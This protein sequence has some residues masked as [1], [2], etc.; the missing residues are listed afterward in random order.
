MMYKIKDYNSQINRILNNTLEESL[1][2]SIKSLKSVLQNLYKKNLEHKINPKNLDLNKDDILNKFSDIIIKYFFALENCNYKPIYEIIFYMIELGADIKN[3][4]NNPISNLIFKITHYSNSNNFNWFIYKILKHVIRKG[5]CINCIYI[6]YRRESL[7]SEVIHKYLIFEDDHNLKYT[8]KIVKLLLNNNYLVTD[9]EDNILFYTYDIQILELLLD[10]G[11]FINHMSEHG[12]TPLHNH[13]LEPSKNFDK[14]IEFL[15]KKG[16]DPNIFTEDF[17]TSLFT[18]MKFRHEASNFFDTVKLMLKYGADPNLLQDEDGYFFTHYMRQKSKKWCGKFIDILIKGGLNI[19]ILNSCGKNIG[20]NADSNMLEVLLEKGMN[21]HQ[22]DCCNQTLLDNIVYNFMN[23][24][25]QPVNDVTER[26]CNDYSKQIDVLHNY[27]ISYNHKDFQG[28]SVM[29]IAC[30]MNLSKQLA[31]RLFIKLF[32]NGAS[33]NIEDCDGEKAI[34]FLSHLSLFYLL[35]FGFI[36]KDSFLLDEILTY[37]QPYQ[38]EEIQD[39]FSKFEPSNALNQKITN[40]IKM[41]KNSI[42]QTLT[43]KIS[44]DIVSH[45]ICN[46]IYP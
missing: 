1:N 7:L 19:N 28:N 30:R 11:F 21:P 45:I 8:V 31:L 13:V 38:M 17:E 10:Y 3:I 40:Y 37:I 20:W 12:N 43:H 42:V 41:R 4:E 2:M 22:K 36:C 46:M 18:Y 27:D 29:H 25:S 9:L 34:V 24:I 33:F 14:R 23:E 32:K 39:E 26:E 35:Q 5:Y 16:A 15:L 44:K 6:N